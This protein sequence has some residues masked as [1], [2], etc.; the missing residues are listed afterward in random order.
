MDIY[1]GG[2]PC[3][4]GCI[5]REAT[6]MYKSHTNGLQICLPSMSCIVKELDSY[7]TIIIFSCKLHVKYKS[8][9]QHIC[10]LNLSDNKSCSSYGTTTML[11]IEDWLSKFLTLNFMLPRVEVTNVPKKTFVD[12][13]QIPEMYFLFRLIHKLNF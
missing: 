4:E 5:R 7:L 9:F 11:Y 13:I 8:P 2:M 12:E 10:F 6:A 1:I 3:K